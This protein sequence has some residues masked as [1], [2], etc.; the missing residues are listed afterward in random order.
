MLQ[1]E[2]HLMR[3]GSIHWNQPY[4][5]GSCNKLP[6]G[7]SMH[8]DNDRSPRTFA[9][10]VRMSAN[11]TSEK[12]IELVE[13]AKRHLAAVLKKD[14]S[15]DHEYTKITNERNQSRSRLWRKSYG[16]MRTVTTPRMHTAGTYLN[17]STKVIS[18]SVAA[19]KRS[20]AVKHQPAYPMKIR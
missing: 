6:P 4:C 20:Q 3:L 15:M 9:N 16:H 17:T 2:S 1:V 8:N 14:I 18:D 11:M 12:Y 19:R 5:D 13:A 10:D 7:S